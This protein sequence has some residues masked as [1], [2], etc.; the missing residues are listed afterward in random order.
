MRRVEGGF[1]LIRCSR[2]RCTDRQGTYI[3]RHSSPTLGEVRTSIVFPMDPSSAGRLALT[4]GVF[5]EADRRRPSPSGDDGARLA[6]P[7]G[8][9]VDISADEFASRI[10]E[11]TP[12]IE[13]A[14]ATQLALDVLNHRDRLPFDLAVALCIRRYYPQLLDDAA[15]ALLASLEDEA[16]SRRFLGRMAIDTLAV[17]PEISKATRPGSAATPLGQCEPLHRRVSSAA[18]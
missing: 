7:E 11:S 2:S 9:D 17:Q 5:A 8:Q 18:V 12:E 15:L 3:G 1:L 14:A 4:A 10:V 13:M 16:S 6:A